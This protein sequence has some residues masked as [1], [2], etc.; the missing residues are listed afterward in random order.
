[1]RHSLHSHIIYLENSIQDVKNRLTRPN[2]TPDDTLDLQLQL[3][4]AES[5]LEHYRRA[6]ELE[7]TIADSEPPNNSAGGE[8]NRGSES[9]AN[10]KST[11]KKE[12][13]VAIE[14][15]ARKRVSRRGRKLAV[16]SRSSNASKPGACRTR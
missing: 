12:G 15:R 11:N 8:S 10:S 16:S 13:L 5:A 4:L 9:P 3:S 6:Y 2:L 7:L 14:A 1:M